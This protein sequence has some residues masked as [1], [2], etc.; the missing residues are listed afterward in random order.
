MLRLLLILFFSFFLIGCSSTTN[1]KYNIEAANINARLGM[2]YL[3]Q[4][5]IELAKKKLLLALKQAPQDVKVHGA[6]GYF[7]AHT[8]ESA[9]AEKHYLFAIKYAYEKGAIWND[10][11]IFL[12]QQNRYQEALKYFLLAAEDLNYLSVAKAYANA[13]EAAMKLKQNK[14]AQQYRKN[15]FLHDPNTGDYFKKYFL[16]QP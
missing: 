8:G 16:I 5:K 14:L 15:A 10:Y 4:N 1:F 12:Y 6:L 11:G 9:L 13:S 3:Q 2:A 7:F